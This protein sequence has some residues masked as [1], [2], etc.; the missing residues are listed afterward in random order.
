MWAQSI[1]DL[2]QARPTTFGTTNG[3]G[4][5]A[6]THTPRECM[7]KGAAIREWRQDTR[8]QTRSLAATYASNLHAASVLKGKTATICTSCQDPTTSSTRRSTASEATYLLVIGGTW[9]VLAHSRDTI[10]LTEEQPLPPMHPRAA[11][12][13]PGKPW[14]ARGSTT[15][16]YSMLRWATADSNPTAQKREERHME[17]QAAEAIRRAQSAGHVA[18]LEGTEVIGRDGD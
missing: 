14:I 17:E 7:Q 6:K 10:G 18:D 13:S 4:E 3:R 16:R 5:I 15:K 8:R 11:L 2:S 9:G 12:N 1:P